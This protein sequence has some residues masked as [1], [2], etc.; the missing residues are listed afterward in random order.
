MGLLYFVGAIYTFK[1]L[2]FHPDV[3]NKDNEFA[4][5][6]INDVRG[7]S[8]Q[9]LENTL[10]SS[11]IFVM[12]AI[13]MGLSFFVLSGCAQVIKT[14]QIRD[15]TSEFSPKTFPIL[16]TEMPAPR[17]LKVTRLQD[18][19]EPSREILLKAVPRSKQILK[20]SQGSK[21]LLFLSTMNPMVEQWIDYFS[22][23]DRERFQ[24]F[25]NRGR[26]YQRAIKEILRE[27]SIPEEFYYL[28][29]IESGYVTFARSHA[30][31]N[32]VWQFIYATGKRYGLEVNHYVDE[33]R[34]PIR[35][36]YAAAHY[37]EDLFNVFQS[38]PLAMASYNAG[39]MRILGA[40]M[41][42]EN[43][44]YWSL[45]AKKLLPRETCNYVPKFLAAYQIGE[46]PE[47]YGFKVEPRSL[48]KLHAV[49][50]PGALRLRD[51]AQASGL[52]L[53]ELKS[54]NPHFRRT[55]TP[56]HSKLYD[57]WLPKNA[58]R[59]LEPRRQQLAQLVSQRRA[60]ATA[61]SSKSGE[62]HIVRAGDNLT[63]IARRYGTSVHA[64]RNANNLRGNRIY[65]NQKL[66]LPPSGRSIIYAAQRGDSLFRIAQRYGTRVSLIK[67]VNNLR[68]NRIYVGQ[69]IRIPVKSTR[70]AK[71]RVKRGDHLT[72]IAS[73]F[74]TSV[75][76]IKKANALRSDRIFRGQVLKISRSGQRQMIYHRVQAGENLSEI[77]RRY[78]VSIQRIKKTNDLELNRIYIDQVLKIQPTI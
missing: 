55:T 2:A 23:K 4:E 11:K 6:C 43:R 21:E 45:C 69:K 42:S 10:S 24:R 26:L 74:G 65:I 57:V 7:P 56:S 73:K 78:D 13:I 30:G 39:E 67:E 51:I 19:V 8:E 40:I 53:K 14:S 9:S 29:M 68:R 18:S 47:K 59:L 28:A 22:K 71:Y 37:L 48:P 58:S 15:Q 33:R 17:S 35:A 72:K 3:R 1:H 31:A 54:F 66:K 60:R 44:D 62:Q 50:L 41:R 77:S 32:G 63:T 46:N 16:K 27:E 75:Y 36:T 70:I 25:L 38:W 49:S 76:A 61:N 5:H 52:S 20:K 64:L 12:R 34:D